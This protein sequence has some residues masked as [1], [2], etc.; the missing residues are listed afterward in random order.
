MNTEKI[1]KGWAL[2]A[3]GAMELSLAYE[4]IDSPVARAGATGTEGAKAFPPPSSVPVPSF[5]EL[6]PDDFIEQVERVTGGTVEP[7]LKPQ[8][9][10]GLGKCPIHGKP[11]TIKAAGVGK[12]GAYDAFWKCAEKDDDGYCTQKPQKIWRDTHPI[13]NGAA[14]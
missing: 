8:V 6:P 9:D 2:I 11:W 7:P 5:D 1:A 14:A 3:E 4:S 13:P 12:K 10:A